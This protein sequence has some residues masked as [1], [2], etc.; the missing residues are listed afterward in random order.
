MSTEIDGTGNSASDTK[1]TKTAAR[2]HSKALGRAPIV[3]GFLMLIL[4]LM[5][6]SLIP[7]AANADEDFRPWFGA[8]IEFPLTPR[9]VAADFSRDGNWLVYANSNPGDPVYTTTAIRLNVID[10]SSENAGDWERVATLELE[11]E[12][13]FFNTSLSDDIAFHPEHDAFAV[14]HLA[15]NEEDGIAFF[16]ASDPN[17]E[18]WQ[19]VQFGNITLSPRPE[20]RSLRF[21]DDGA[22]LAVGIGISTLDDEF[23]LGWDVFDT[24]DPD[25]A[26]WDFADVRPQTIS[27]DNALGGSAQ[28]SA[29]SPDGDLLVFV[30]HTEQDGN[31]DQ[32]ITV[33]DSSGEQWFALFTQPNVSERASGVDFH[34]SGQWFLVAYGGGIRLFDAAS[35]NEVSGFN[36]DI[37]GGGGS[38]RFSSDGNVLAVS[39]F[40]EVGDEGIRWIDSSSSNPADWTIDD[41]IGPVDL[42]SSARGI[43]FSSDDEYV[44]MAH[45]NEPF[46][47][48]AQ[49]LRSPSS[50]RDVSANYVEGSFDQFINQGEIAVSWQHPERDGGAGIDRYE[51]RSSDGA[52][53][54]RV[55]DSDATS[56]VLTFDS[57]ELADPSLVPLELVAVGE[58]NL[59]GPAA[60][61]AAA[62]PTTPGLVSA[63]EPTALEVNDGVAAWTFAWQ[64]PEDD[65]GTALTG[66]RVRIELASGGQNLFPVA[67]ESIEVEFGLDGGQIS[68]AAENDFG[69]GERVS[70]SVPTL[71]EPAFADDPAF[72]AVRAAGDSHFDVDVQ[73]SPVANWGFVGTDEA[74]PGDYVFTFETAGGSIEVTR[75][76]GSGAAEILA[77]LT[78]PAEQLSAGEGTTVRAR[79]EH[80]VASSPRSTNIP[81]FIDSINPLSKLSASQPIWDEVAK[82][83]VTNISW[84]DYHPFSA[85]DSA[86]ALLEGGDV[87]AGTVTVVVTNSPPAAAPT[88]GNISDLPLDNASAPDFG[89]ATAQVRISDF[90]AEELVSSEVSTSIP[91]VDRPQAPVVIVTNPRFTGKVLL[92]DLELELEDRAEHLA[93]IVD[94]QVASAD[95]G[96]TL[97]IDT[98]LGGNPSGTLSVDLAIAEYRNP[99]IGST[100]P[101]AMVALLDAAGLG[102]ESAVAEALEVPDPAPVTIAGQ[103]LSFKD[104]D[105]ILDLD[106]EISDVESAGPSEAFAVTFGGEEVAV[107]SVAGD[108]ENVTISISIPISELVT[109]TD[110]TVVR[111]SI[112]GA[113]SDPIRAQI[114]GLGD[115][116]FFDAFEGI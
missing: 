25:P 104:D 26:N 79:N 16:D 116:V 6:L 96:V 64:A 99:E 97:S 76:G 81:V 59:E 102:G 101:A 103:S 45:R 80:G 46:A 5:A 94:T 29:F 114:D 95:D 68:I 88:S 52:F 107:Q 58:G 41:S 21:S 48:V 111:T 85:G 106:I 31:S 2:E 32:H 87:P 66:Y 70:T 86:L 51:L 27:G 74:Q 73:V 18:N 37:G 23:N 10:S 105:A 55:L 12:S 28:D 84:A 67:D 83:Y 112:T 53:G 54:D 89:D 30:H 36:I 60:G 4:G 39:F 8:D 71:T 15:T 1:H 19:Q 9:G 44:A 20:G 82:T 40:N 57:A 3:S 98:Q 22:F 113:N 14:T 109:D 47:T 78:I 49:R 92:H 65:G 115:S 75:E 35:M 7:V 13:G 17:P 33:I 34:P 72:V 24:S 77:T 108:E 11:S 38:P 62:L 93:P 69:E 100:Y 90:V 61:A 56:V 91:S 43:A 42:P 110:V 63:L 50:P